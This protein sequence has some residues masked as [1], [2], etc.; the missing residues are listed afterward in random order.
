MAAE[1]SRFLKGEYWHVIC[2]VLRQIKTYN[3]RCVMDMNKMQVGT[4]GLFRQNNLNQAE[5]EKLN[6]E[7]SDAG[8]SKAVRPQEASAA[9]DNVSISNVWRQVSQNID[10]RSASPRDIIS[11]SSQLYNA[12]AISYADHI[13]LSCQPEIN[14]DTPPE[15]KPFS[16]EKKDYVDLWRTKQENVIRYGGDRTQIEDTHRIQAILIYVDSLR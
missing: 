7:K 16:H 15:S 13:N 14:L 1:F 10:V 9:V 3:E 4:E 6:I 12:G 8:K 11:L 5:R 2:C